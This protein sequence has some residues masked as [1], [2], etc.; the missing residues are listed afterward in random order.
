MER[1]IQ[2][3]DEVD[4][5]CAALRHRLGWWPASRRFRHAARII[6]ARIARTALQAPSP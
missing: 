2:I 4:D 1:L 6:T 5:L 3:L